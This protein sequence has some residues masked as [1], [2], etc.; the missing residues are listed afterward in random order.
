MKE[1]PI[2]TP[3]FERL[4]KGF[5]SELDKEKDNELYTYEK[6]SYLKEFFCY[7][8]MHGKR[9]LK[10]IDQEFTDQYLKYLETER[11][12]E[13]RGG[14]LSEDT[15]NKHKGAIRLF[16]RYCIKEEIEVNNIVVKQKK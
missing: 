6:S 9:K 2:Y 12:N 13:R 15:I 4:V 16:L 14:L 10:Q 11:K 8:E 5:A 7:C 1:T 3:E